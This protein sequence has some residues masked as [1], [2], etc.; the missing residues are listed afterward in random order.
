MRKHGKKILLALFICFAVILIGFTSASLSIWSYSKENQLVQTDAAVV[1]G[2]AI[3]DDEP[4]PVFRER[5]NHSIWLYDNDYVEYLFFTG[6]KGDG[7]QYSESEVAR[8]YAIEQGVAPDDI[9]IEEVST[10]T[11]ENLEQVLIVSD[12]E[13]IESYTLVSDPLHMKRA[14]LMAEDLG[15]EAYSSP[16]QTSA[17]TSWG[18]QMPFLARETFFYVGYMLVKPFR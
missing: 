6:G 1:L 7:E 11:E 14:M 3:W 4:S 12:E 10:I 15:M 13:P 16:T 18:S 8:Q 17:Y 9:L 5:I 2:A